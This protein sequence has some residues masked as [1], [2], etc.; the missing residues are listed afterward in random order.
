MTISD[1]YNYFV[2]RLG[3]RF[4]QCVFCR[5]YSAYFVGPEF[6]LGPTVRIL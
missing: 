3:L 6:V 2:L 5:T 4:I 1:I